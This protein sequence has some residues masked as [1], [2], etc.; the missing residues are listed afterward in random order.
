[1]DTYVTLQKLVIIYKPLKSWVLIGA[2]T[3]NSFALH[4]T[5]IKF[6]SKGVKLRL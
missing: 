2:T 1:M 5:S 6:G 3:M 4:A